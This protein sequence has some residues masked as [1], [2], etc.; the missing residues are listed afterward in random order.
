MFLNKIELLFCLSFL[1]YFFMVKGECYE[2]PLHVYYT[3]IFPPS[4]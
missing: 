2:T 1:F 3:C 4:G